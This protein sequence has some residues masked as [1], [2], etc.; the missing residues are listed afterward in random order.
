MR[1]SLQDLLRQHGMP[2]KYC[3]KLK[4][5]K[6]VEPEDGV[7]TYAANNTSDQWVRAMQRQL[8]IVEADNYMLIRL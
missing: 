6:L 3:Q 7:I 5:L 4:L 2:A 8:W 1:A